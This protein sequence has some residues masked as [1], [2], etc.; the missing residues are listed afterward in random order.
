MLTIHKSFW[1]NYNINI[2]NIVL[3]NNNNNIV[4]VNFRSIEANKFYDS[5]NANNSNSN[6][7]NNS[8]NG[9]NL[10]NNRCNWLKSHRK[11]NTDI[12]TIQC[13]RLRQK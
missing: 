5:K 3:H 4:L 8:N 11:F 6:N 10:N 9:N 13:H 7:N 2:Q 12:K 1:T